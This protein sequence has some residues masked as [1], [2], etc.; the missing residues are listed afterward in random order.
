[1]KKQGL[2]VH[3]HGWKSKILRVMRL[4]VIMM[5][6][7]TL[8]SALPGLGQQQIK[9]EVKGATLEQVLKELRALS[10]YYI[11][12]NIQ[13]VRAVKGVDLKV[14]N[15][16]VEEVLKLC[17][18]NTN[19]VYEISDKT[20]LISAKK[21]TVS[22]PQQRERRIHGVVKDEQGHRLAGVVVFLKSNPRQGT[23]TDS[24]GFFSIN[25]KDGIEEKLL[26]RFVGM[27]S[28]VVPVTKVMVYE[29]VMREKVEEV[30]EVVVTGYQTI[31]KELSAAST[32]TVKMEDVMVPGATSV[33][34]VLQGEIPGLMLLY[35]SGSPSSLPKVRMRGTATLL[36]NAAPVWV[37]DGVIQED[38]MNLS[39]EDIMA[40][41]DGE[42]YSMFGNAI[43]G[44]NPMD[45]ESITFLKDAAATA[46]YGTKAANG[47]IVVTTKKGSAR[48]MTVS[49]T[50]NLKF[51]ERPS[52]RKSANMMNSKQRM[53]ITKEMFDDCLVFEVL[54]QYGFEKTM[55]DYLNG[56]GSLEDALK[57]YQYREQLNT[58]WFDLLFENTVSDNHSLS[59]S[60]GN[61]NTTYYVSLGLANDR[62]TQKGDDTKRYT[63]N[64]R[65]NTELAKWLKADLK[66]GYS[67]RKV[68]GFMGTTPMYYALQTSRTIAPDERYI[69]EIKSLSG[70]VDGI[71]YKFENPI[72]FNIFDEL[73]N[74]SKKTQTTEFSAS[75]NLKMD[76]WKGLRGELLFAYKEAHGVE[77][78][79]ATE[80][81]AYM[82]RKRGYDY[83]TVDIGGMESKLSQYPYGG[84]YQ[85][86][87]QDNNR[88]ELR[89]TLR[90][91]HVWKEAHSL[92]LMG[93]GQISSQKS[94]GFNSSDYGYFPD[95]GKT[96]F[97]EYNKDDSGFLGNNYGSSTSKHRVTLSDRPNNA[98]KVMAAL[99]YDYKRR[100]VLNA[101]FS[102]DGTNR[103]GDNKKFRF[104]PIW[105]VSG[106]WNMLEEK[107]MK[108][109]NLLSALDV[110][111]S[112]G[113]QGN[114]VYGVSPKLIA[115][116]LTGNN[117]INPYVGEFQL[118]LRNIPNSDLDWEKTRTVN[119]GVDL[120]FWK[121]RFSLS[122]EYYIK[123]GDKVLYDRQL[124]LAY[125]VEKTYFN[126]SKLTNEGVELSLRGN[127]VKTKDWNFVLSA[128]VAF[129]RNEV[130][131]PGYRD[132]Y[133]SY[134]NGYSAFS[135]Y[136]VGSFWSWNFKELGSNGMPIFDL[137][138]NTSYTK[139][140]L[141]SDP[142]KYLV[143]SGSKNP[144][145]VGGFN[146]NL[147]YRNLSFN[148]S[149]AFALGAMKRLRT[150]YQKGQ[151]T[152]T[153]PKF[154]ANLPVEFVEHWRKSGDENTT[155][156][157]GFLRPTE[158]A[159][160]IHPGGTSNIYEMWD[161]SQHRVVSADFMR[162][163]S[164]TLTYKVPEKILSNVK[165]SFLSFSLTGTNLFVIK[166]K[167]LHKEDPE[168]GSM[169]VPILPSYN[170]SIN[171]NL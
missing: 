151:Y 111:V 15:A 61:Q 86:R 146:V 1:M 71:K 131:R 2:I 36:G 104:S 50:G 17:L 49:Y 59:V 42:D 98:V 58:D 135:G 54:P 137:G 51:T 124:P 13:D 108:D 150:V 94:S 69:T 80:Q 156:K 138:E 85:R 112:Y 119:F 145:I 130:K 39:N 22:Q 60:G 23:V 133:L 96:I 147:S 75:A 62:G 82:A 40:L 167:R 78:G 139:E 87:D 43:S 53:A 4:I 11:L 95:R 66:M 84:Y 77:I 21:A 127:V 5:L 81:S 113:F 18:K 19:L 76:I 121:N 41:S 65:V 120:G 6:F 93:G 97:Y 8:L 33:E 100:Y 149:F 89:G 28:Q 125:G 24:L 10:G 142:M 26:V 165:L 122:A 92:N 52:Y 126:D 164:M 30:D 140:E 158:S 109:Q 110:K 72:T 160:C 107:W 67:S 148:S 27:E 170:F 63:A 48:K 144:D 154:D 91:T 37:V 106:R 136:S 143:H 134:L 46:I 7:P 114:V 171:L 117:A 20:I 163:K 34:D 169:N 35:G 141:R 45:I 132:V 64:V 83:G 99:V 161:A 25:V 118:Q 123:F 31:A 73:A 116:Y 103:F 29:I 155:N 102:V 90:F 12:Y 128:N 162:C 157:P 166:N 3:L 101:S 68:W 79:Y 16:T 55:I 129:T 115:G 153:V 57:E 47:V 32:Y 168:A 38:I 9:M 74:T 159:S 56:K 105:S 44:L 14:K 152:V 70:D 88:W